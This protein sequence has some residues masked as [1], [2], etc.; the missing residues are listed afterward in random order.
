M[1]E[2]RRRAINFGLDEGIAEII[3]WIIGVHNESNLSLLPYGS[4]PVGAYEVNIRLLSAIFKLADILHTDYQRISLQV[5]EFNNARFSDNPKTLFRYRIRG[6]RFDKYG[7]IELFAVPKS[8]DEL[9][10]INK[11]FE[12]CRQEVEPIVPILE[13]V[14]FPNEL[15]LYLDETDLEHQAFESSREENTILHSFIGM[16]SFR[17]SESHAFKGRDEEIKILSRKISAYPIMLLVGDSGIGKTSLIRA[18]LIPYL[19]YLNWQ[20][21]YTDPIDK[22]DFSANKLYY[23]LFK[24]EPENTINI[25]DSFEL[26]SKNK[27]INKHLIIFDQFEEIIRCSTSK[28]VSQLQQAL[29][30]IQSGKYDKLKIL[31][32]YRGEHE[33]SI[34]HFFQK[35]LGTDRGLPR[36]FLAPLSKIGANKALETGFINAA[37]D[38]DMP[39][40]NR[41]V[42]D[43]ASE[44][45]TDSVFPPYLQMVGESIVTLAIERNIKKLTLKFYDQI[46]SARQ[47]IGSYLLNRLEGLGD[48]KDSALKILISLTSTA[49]DVRVQKTVDELIKETGIYRNSIVGLLEQLVNSRMI[50]GLK[51]NSFQI[52]HEYMAE[53]IRDNY[54]D[55]ERYNIKMANEFLKRKEIDYTVNL[56][57][58][59]AKEMSLFY[60]I[61]DYLFPNRDELKMLLHSCLRGYGPVWY[62]FQTIPKAGALEIFRKLFS[63]SDLTVRKALIPVLFDLLG[64]Q[65]FVEFSNIKKEELEAI[66][67]EIELQVEKIGSDEIRRKLY[68]E[69]K[70]SNSMLYLQRSDILNMAKETLLS[71]RTI[72]Y[73]KAINIYD[74]T[75]KRLIINGLL[76]AL[77]NIYYNKNYNDGLSGTIESSNTHA[78]IATKSK[79]N[80]SI[81]IKTKK[82]PFNYNVLKFRKNY[83]VAIQQAKLKIEEGVFKELLD[84][85]N[86][87]DDDLCKKILLD[88][89][90]FNT[91][92]TLQI[93]VDFIS[94]NNEIKDVR[95]LAIEYLIYLVECLDI[96]NLEMVGDYIIKRPFLWFL[97]ETGNLARLASKLGNYSI[98]ALK[99]LMDNQYAP[100]RD[101]AIRSIGSIMGRDSI[102]I[103]K[104]KLL[105]ENELIRLS[106]YETLAKLVNKSDLTWLSEWIYNN[107]QSEMMQMVNLLIISLDY[108]LYYN[109]FIKNMEDKQN[110]VELL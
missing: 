10:V 6:W 63:N 67:N 24:I 38:F 40:V 44:T 80:E 59:S 81:N 82:K 12:L 9:E 95:T 18:G 100:N 94:N 96:R 21:T 54:S 62:W 69:I 33:S 98:P 78:V 110:R 83:D 97:C 64:K 102:S 91:E 53:Q 89:A 13:E 22:D 39:F 17:E 26:A 93:M 65:A 79:F 103:L 3:G 31:A 15:T 48:L 34:G 47:L 72:E 35:L 49:G 85:C 88:L 36:L 7:R 73:A 104:S 84:L 70:R 74:K 99:F 32:S 76:G 57:L 23:D 14:D 20:I 107:S 56:S 68:F 4:L 106:A 50:R 46:G 27:N 86:C 43:L 25:V 28:Q 105:D 19:R 55:P 71:A 77:D 5:V 61:R 92:K 60:S 52:I 37:L 66:K 2:V 108:K 41:V 16:D 51:N 11:G 29:L 1:W 45:T 90:T 58:L 8:W 109:T 101:E 42:K 75:Q 87:G 30:S